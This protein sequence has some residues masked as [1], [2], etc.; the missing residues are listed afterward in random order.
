MEE[1]NWQEIIL[2]L[3]QEK[4]EETSPSQDIQHEDKDTSV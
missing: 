2:K 3:N 1:K 4:E